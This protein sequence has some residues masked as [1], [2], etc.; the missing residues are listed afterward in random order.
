MPL[1]CRQTRAKQEEPFGI[2]ASQLSF[3]AH[4]KEDIFTVK[5]CHTATIKPA[6]KA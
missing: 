3:V 5:Y 4:K 6:V 2:V 1:D